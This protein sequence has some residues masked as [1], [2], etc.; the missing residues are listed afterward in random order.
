MPKRR[1]NPSWESEEW[2]KG[3]WLEKNE[4][5]SDTDD[6]HQDARC[7]VCRVN[8][9]SHS[10]DLQRHGK[11]KSPTDKMSSIR[12]PTKSK[13]LNYVKKPVSEKLKIAAINISTHVAVHS[14]IRTVDHL[15]DV[16]KPLAK[17]SPLEDLKLKRTK[18]TSTIKN[19]IAPVMLTELVEAIG[20]N[21][22]SLIVDESTDVSVTKYMCLCV[23]YFNTTE[24]KLV[25]DF[26]GMFLVEKATAKC[27]YESVCEY[28]ETIKL[29]KEN[30]TALGTDGASNLCWR[31]ESLYALLKKDIP[32]LQLLKCSCHSIH[33]CS[34]KAS[35]ELPSS[36]E[37]LVKEVYNWFKQSTLRRVKYK[38]LFDT[39]NAG[40][41][42]NRFYQLIQLSQTR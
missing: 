11:A 16:V 17:G 18:C 40:V 35:E 38:R 4:D 8:L 20:K 33:L 15:V 36:L 29:P 19:V 9:R 6:S 24:G 28:L 3:W 23:K 37:Y 26:L 1:Y 42:S 39:I 32:N 34:C 13:M 12:L 21:G 31:K 14:A 5:K 41:E 25:T 22:Y 2:A 30:M 10:S 7:K 27:L